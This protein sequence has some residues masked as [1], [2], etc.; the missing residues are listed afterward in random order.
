MK[1]PAAVAATFEPYYRIEGLEQWRLK[2]YAKLLHIYIY[3]ARRS[4]D[5][6][7]CF[8]GIRAERG[9]SFQ[10]VTITLRFRDLCYVPLQQVIRAQQPLLQT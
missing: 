8:V 6:V 3:D 5:G 9:R 1:Q 7:Y 10:S 4:E 2:G